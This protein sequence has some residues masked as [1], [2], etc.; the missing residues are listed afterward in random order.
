[1]PRNDEVG[2]NDGGR[3]VIVVPLLL[4][5]ITEGERDVMAW[6]MG[7]EKSSVG[8]EVIREVE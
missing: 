8:K 1:M 2:G 7:V 4:L 5:L 3:L 6:V